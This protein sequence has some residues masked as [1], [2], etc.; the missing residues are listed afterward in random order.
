MRIDTLQLAKELKRGLKPL[1]TIYGDEPLVAMEAADAIREVARK[2]GATRETFDVEPGFDW[3]KFGAASA[4]MSL[5]ASV[6]LLELRIPTGKPGRAGG[7]AIQRYCEQVATSSD[8]T[9]VLLPALDWT[10][11]KAQWFGALE[12]S[13]VMVEAKPLAR[14]ALPEWLSERLARQEQ[15]TDGQTLE[16]FA[17]QIEGNL[18]AGWQEVQKLG[19]QYGPGAL[20]AEQ[21][22]SSVND[23]AR[24]DTDRLIEAMVTGDLSK[25]LRVLDGLRAEGENIVMLS[26]RIINEVRSALTIAQAGGKAAP[27]GGARQQ[28]AMH[29]AKKLGADRL[30]MLL[31]RRCQQLDRASKGLPTAGLGL[32]DPW[33]VVTEICA[34]LTSRAGVPDPV[35]R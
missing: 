6:R 9:L 32:V 10:T 20:T 24:Y 14:S 22:K 21:V 3:A 26:W 11:L 27:Y 17:D 31:E 18:L 30:R 35:Q 23:V 2:G 4:E 29:F 34:R 5:F 19:L 12:R 1:Y 16:W 13:G 25:T 28:S 33:T 15:S 8:V 7:D